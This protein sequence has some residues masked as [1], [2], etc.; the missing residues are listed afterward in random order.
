ML[1]DGLQ[2]LEQITEKSDWMNLSLQERFRALGWGELKDSNSLKIYQ[3]AHHLEPSGLVDGKVEELLNRSMAT[4]IHLLL[5]SMGR[6]H[7]SPLRGESSFIRVNIPAYRAEYW[8]KGVYQ[9]HFRVV[10][11]DLEGETPEFQREIKSI[12]LN[13]TWYVPGSVKERDLNQR[14]KKNP[15]F[16]KDNGFRLIGGGKRLV[17]KPGEGNWLGRVIFRWDRGGTKSVFIHD[18]PFQERFERSARAMSHGCVNLEGARDLARKLAIL[19]GGISAAGFDRLLKTGKT[20]RIPLRRSLTT[21]LEY[22]TVVPGPE[23]QLVFLPDVYNRIPPESGDL[24]LR[25][26]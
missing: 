25:Q 7:R 11:G 6:W 22:T 21:V 13:P 26:D 1:V 5:E 19:R 10:V 8:E 24:A 16:Y 17:Q 2:R 12:V 9:E 4:H 14:L 18:S 20:R 3:K 15:N 23:G